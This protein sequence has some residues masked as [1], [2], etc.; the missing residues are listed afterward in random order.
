MQAL[1]EFKHF[2]PG[3][4]EKEIEK[5]VANAVRYLEDIQW[6]DGSW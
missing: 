6:E 5:A 1:I 3:H 2:H 4:R